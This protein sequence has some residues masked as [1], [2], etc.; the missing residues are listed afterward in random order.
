YITHKQGV[1]R[2][3]RLRLI[4]LVDEED[5]DAVGRVARCVDGFECDVTQRDTL[6]VVE[7]LVGVVGTQ[8]GTD[9]Y[10]CTGSLMQFEVRTY[11]VGMRV[12][13]DDSGNPGPL[14]FGKV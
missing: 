9:I 3:Y 5:T 1:A 8:Q 10:C 4:M 11:K 14:L 2:K 12:G 7:R 6:T 13:L